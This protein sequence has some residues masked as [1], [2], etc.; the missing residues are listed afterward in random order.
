MPECIGQAEAANKLKGGYCVDQHMV[1]TYVLDAKQLLKEI[2]V[3]LAL[4]QWAYM[5]N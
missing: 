3:Q 2:L 1:I 5:I 4:I